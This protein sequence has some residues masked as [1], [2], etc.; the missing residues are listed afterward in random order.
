MT[1]SIEDIL[2]CIPRH[3]CQDG[4]R[5]PRRSSI[6]HQSCPP[7]RWG[8]CS[9]AIRGNKALL[10]CG[11]EGN[12]PVDFYLQNNSIRNRYS[13]PWMDWNRSRLGLADGREHCMTAQPLM[14]RLSLRSPCFHCSV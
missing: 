13:S 6:G 7:A 1:K 14:L 5:H 8:K 4:C 11:L 9:D 2:V 3:W 12:V 10:D